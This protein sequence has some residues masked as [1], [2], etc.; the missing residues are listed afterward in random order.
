MRPELSSRQWGIKMRAIKGGKRCQAAYRRQGRVGQ[1][2]PAI[3]AGR[4]AVVRR[5]ARALRHVP[6]QHRFLPIA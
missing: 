4:I 6:T 3:K 1:K 2:H 5:R